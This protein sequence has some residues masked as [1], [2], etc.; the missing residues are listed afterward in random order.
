MIFLLVSNSNLALLFFASKSVV[1]IKTG[2]SVTFVHTIRTN[3][4]EANLAACLENVWIY[5]SI[6]IL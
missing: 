6:L 4:L 5:L 2:E 3:Q 1:A